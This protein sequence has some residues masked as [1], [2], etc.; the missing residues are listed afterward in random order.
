MI[1]QFRQGDVLVQVI[2]KLPSKLQEAK[3]AENRIVLQYGEVTGHA[4]AIHNTKGVTAFL[5]PGEDATLVRGM[6]TGRR[7]FL[8]VKEKS[9]LT[10]EEHSAI[11]LEPG[12]Y[13]VIRQR[14]YT[15]EALRFVN[16]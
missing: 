2:D 3:E 15:P 16:D 10:H 6:E 13:E 14:Q 8:Q 1:K 11:V 12:N 4:H 9:N 5:E 7:G